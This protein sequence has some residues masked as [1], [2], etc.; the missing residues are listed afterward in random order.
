MSDRRA[1]ERESCP[2]PSGIP[3]AWRC[4]HLEGAYRSFGAAQ[5]YRRQRPSRYGGIPL[6]V[7][8]S[9]PIIHS[10]SHGAGARLGYSAI[11]R[12]C[13]LCRSFNNHVW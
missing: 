7:E 2:R 3:R 8:D 6:P 5:L 1:V 11:I 10:G 12:A 4:V 9:V 13:M